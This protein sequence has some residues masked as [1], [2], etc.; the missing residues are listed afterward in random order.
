MYHPP[1]T[2]WHVRIS[3]K[4]LTELFAINPKNK[5]SEEQTQINIKQQSILLSI[6]LN[7][8]KQILHMQDFPES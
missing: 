5:P 7:P 6:F 1:S 8:S 3:R 4:R 2:T